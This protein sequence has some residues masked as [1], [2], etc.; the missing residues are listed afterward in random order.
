MTR[1]AAIER[2]LEYFDGGRY[3]D[4]LARRVAIPTESKIPNVCPIFFD[5]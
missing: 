3:T 5:I 2:A 1:T 4:D